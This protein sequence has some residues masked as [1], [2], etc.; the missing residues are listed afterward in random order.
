MSVA[1]SWI[2]WPFQ[3]TARY[4]KLT[5]KR[6][7]R[8]SLHGK[9][10]IWFLTFFYI[11]LIAAVVVIT[12][13]RIGQFFYD[14]A[15]KISHYQ[16]GWLVLGS[17]MVLVCFPPFVG[18][19]TA[20]TLC[21]FAYG[22]KGAFVAAPAALLGSAIVFVTLRFLFKKKLRQWSATNEKWQ[23]LEAVIRAKGLPLIILIRLSPLPPWVYSNALFASIQAVSLWQ[24]VV[25]TTCL[26]PKILLHVFIGSRLAALS[27]DKSRREMDTQTKLINGISIA[28][29]ILFG[30]IAG[31]VVYYQMQKQV[32]HLQ[33]TGL[34]PSTEDLAAEAIDEAGIEGAPLLA[35]FSNESL[36]VDD[37]YDLDLEEGG[38]NGEECRAD[39]KNNGAVQTGVAGRDGSRQ[40]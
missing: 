12:P 20:V 28:A 35:N 37:N 39:A 14:L 6:Y 36:G 26:L 3:L 10:L 19:T 29:G 5:W 24:F 7:S 21:G 9:L 13:A 1:Q 11:S 40:R 33:G 18:F 38:G 23:A 15:Q 8:L 32:H 27:D 34:P 30:V 31:W 16:F 4:A 17:V 25:A 22:M 2:V